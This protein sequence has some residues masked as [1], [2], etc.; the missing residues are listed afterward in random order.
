[1]SFLHFGC[2]SFDV[3]ELYVITLCVKAILPNSAKDVHVQLIKLNTLKKISTFL[4][5]E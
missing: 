3:K 1:M 4:L 5:V 2:M